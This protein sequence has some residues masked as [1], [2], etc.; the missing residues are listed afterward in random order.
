MIQSSYPNQTR[1][2]SSSF[3]VP[4]SEQHDLNPDYWDAYKKEQDLVI[5]HCPSA[6]GFPQW[7]MYHDTVLASLPPAAPY[8]SAAVGTNACVLDA[9]NWEWEENPESGNNM[10]YEQ[11]GRRTHH[12]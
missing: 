8:D 12:G 11:A 9:S 4:T 5:Q 7:G 2:L 1:P 6:T 10:V 3:A